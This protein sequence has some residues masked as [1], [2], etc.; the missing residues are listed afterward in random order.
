MRAVEAVD[1][2]RRLV[3]TVLRARGRL[4]GARP[5]EIVAGE[6]VR[7]ACAHAAGPCLVTLRWDGRVLRI[8]VVDHTPDALPRGTGLG[9]SIV[10][11]LSTRRGVDVWSSHKRV[12]S[13]VAVAA[14]GAK[15]RLHNA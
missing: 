2:A 3:R 4:G 9:W 7:N 14:H 15:R 1:H 8:E 10:R 11:E 6:L 12:W 13:E 5:A